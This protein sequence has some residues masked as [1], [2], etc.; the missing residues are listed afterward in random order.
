MRGWL[1]FIGKVSSLGKALASRALGNDLHEHR[2][3]EAPGLR[4]PGGQGRCTNTVGSEQRMS[5]VG[6]AVGTFARTPLGTSKVLAV[7]LAVGAGLGGR[8][9]Q[10]EGPDDIDVDLLEFVVDARDSDRSELRD[11]KA[12]VDNERKN[13]RKRLTSTEKRELRLNIEALK[14]QR[15][16]VEKFKADTKFV[17]PTALESLTS[18]FSG[19]GAPADSEKL[20]TFLDEFFKTKPAGS[21]TVTESVANKEFKKVLASLVDAAKSAGISTEKFSSTAEALLADPKNSVAIGNFDFESQ[22]LKEQILKI[23]APKAGEQTPKTKLLYILRQLDQDAM[24]LQPPT[25]AT[26]ALVDSTGKWKSDG[27]AVGKNGLKMHLE[28][29]KNTSGT[30]KKYKVQYKFNLD[31]ETIKRLKG[32]KFSKLTD[33]Q[34][35][36]I[37]KQLEEAT[38]LGKTLEFDGTEDAKKVI[39]Q[40][41]RNLDRDGKKDLRDDA[42]ALLNNILDDYGSEKDGSSKIGELHT[43]Y[44]N[45]TSDAGLVAKAYDNKLKVIEWLKTNSAKGKNSCE[46]LVAAVKWADLDSKTQQDCAEYNPDAKS[47]LAGDISKAMNSAKDKQDAE[48]KKSQSERDQERAQQQQ[49]LAALNA[50]MQ[51]LTSFCEAFKKAEGFKASQQQTFGKLEMLENAL[52]KT[53]STSSIFVQQCGKMVEGGDMASEL[54]FGQGK[55]DNEINRAMMIAADMPNN[56]KGNLDLQ[57][58]VSDLQRVVSGAWS[59]MMQG[60]SIKQAADVEFQFVN[61][62]VLSQEI[63]ARAQ[64]LQQNLGGV[65]VNQS[66]NSILTEARKGEEFSRLAAE[67]FSKLGSFYNCALTALKGAQAE[68]NKRIASSGPG[69]RMGGG[70]A[71]RDSVPVIG[72]GGGAAAAGRRQF[73]NQGPNPRPGQAGSKG[74]NDRQGGNVRPG[75]MR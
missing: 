39:D 29:S 24:F 22:A 53:G 75:T 54:L 13:A 56:E 51:G 17:A 37:N 52:V 69:A 70:A 25:A 36:E 67:N 3:L 62:Q 73:S 6:L 47:K 30:G 21:G 74:T 71:N 12:E 11:L 35:A 9:A 38:G 15:A 7:A 68:L 42:T 50:K 63:S 33:D 65:D 46:V 55:A 40:L 27:I 45:A 60:E 26:P 59:A 64:A 43:E 23:P 58:E 32:G 20:D 72:G 28:I 34:I 8:L 2:W 49:K 41:K 1:H 16:L 57:Q 66:A 18:A 44:T 19:A 4:A 10:A 61:S 48:Q 14:T 31:A 5:R